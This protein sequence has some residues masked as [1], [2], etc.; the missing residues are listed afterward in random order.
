MAFV[1]LIT[2]QNKGR[3]ILYI[4]KNI[5]REVKIIKQHEITTNTHQL[6]RHRK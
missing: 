3:I 6:M 5:S 4:Y 2:I 1:T